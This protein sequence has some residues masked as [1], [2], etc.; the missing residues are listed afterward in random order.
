MF[1]E[2]RQAGGVTG[3]CQVGSPTTRLGPPG[4]GNI[5]VESI[6]TPTG[7]CNSSY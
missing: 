3:V 6:R 4:V 7:D 2:R 1:E 5:C